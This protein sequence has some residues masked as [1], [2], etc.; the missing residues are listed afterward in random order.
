[1]HIFEKNLTLRSVN[2]QTKY[3][4]TKTRGKGNFRAQKVFIN[5][6]QDNFVIKGF[7]EKEQERASMSEYMD[8]RYNQV[9]TGMQSEAVKPNSS[10]AVSNPKAINPKNPNFINSSDLSN[11]AGYGLELEREKYQKK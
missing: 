10:A 8:W 2:N 6:T 11:E 9:S 1:M 5:T 3:S 7:I 4:F